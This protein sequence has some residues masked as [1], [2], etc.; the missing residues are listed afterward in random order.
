MRVYSR[1]KE[2]K[3]RIAGILAM[4]RRSIKEEEE[5]VHQPTL[6]IGDVTSSMQRQREREYRVYTEGLCARQREPQVSITY[7]LMVSQREEMPIV[8]LF[9]LL[10]YTSVYY[11]DDYSNC[12][13]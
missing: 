11:V 4:Q 2:E 9:F 5:R 1:G 6:N 10:L 3:S 12:P 8:K 7:I 13:V